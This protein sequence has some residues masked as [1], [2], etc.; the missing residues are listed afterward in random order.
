MAATEEHAY[1]KRTVHSYG[2]DGI[3]RLKSELC[4]ESTVY[5]QDQWDALAVMVLQPYD[6]EILRNRL[7]VKTHGI[8]GLY[9]LVGHDVTWGKVFDAADKLG[10]EGL[11]TIFC[12]GDRPFADYRYNMDKI[13][14]QL[15]NGTLL[16][17]DLPASAFALWK[18]DEQ[19][20]VCFLKR[21]VFEEPSE[22]RPRF[23]F[24]K[25]GVDLWQVK[26]MFS[27]F[28]HVLPHARYTDNTVSRFLNVL[29]YTGNVACAQ[30]VL[31]FLKFNFDFRPVRLVP[32]GHFVDMTTIKSVVGTCSSCVAHYSAWSETFLPS[33]I[34]LDH[35]K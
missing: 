1:C 29:I 2:R 6:V 27:F 18:T 34:S 19:N 11:R 10:M 16:L 15:F 9:D 21:F 24:P 12:R 31:T 25:D 26:D 4:R 3:E 32:C 20:F 7:G 8:I 22:L 35:T 28:K 30:D 33:P 5:S 23:V 13:K 17:K 14:S